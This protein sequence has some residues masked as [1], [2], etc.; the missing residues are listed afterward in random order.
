MNYS[1]VFLT[2]AQDKNEA[3]IQWYLEISEYAANQ[4]ITAV[5]FALDLICEHPER[6]RTTDQRFCE[7]GVKK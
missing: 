1:Y 3:S 5:D 7:L 6:W 2:A 4:F